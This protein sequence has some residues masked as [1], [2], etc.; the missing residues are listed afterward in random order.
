MPKPKLEFPLFTGV[1]I[2]GWLYTMEQVLD[3]YQ[4]EREQ[5]VRMAAM[6]LHGSSLQWYRWLMRTGR[7]VPPWAELEK[8]LLNLYGGRTVAGYSSELSK[9]KQEGNTC[10]QYQGEFMKLS[11][12]VQELPEE[13]LVGCFIGGLRDAIKY[14][15]IAKNPP[16]IEEAMRLARVEEEKLSNQRK[17]FKGSFQ[18]QNPSGGTTSG[19]GGVHPSRLT[20]STTIP[21]SSS[22]TKRLSP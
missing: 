13:F 16:T 4:I 7:G 10:E 6:H 22:P 2:E 14:E 9:L 1:D 19:G 12:Q 11:H 21:H 8:K 3:F 15:I 20:G 17:G 18:R 5:R